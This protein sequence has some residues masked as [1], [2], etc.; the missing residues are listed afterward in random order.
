MNRVKL[1]KLRYST[2]WRGKENLQEACVRK[3]SQSK[4]TH[5]YSRLPSGKGFGG[6]VKGE[7]KG[8]TFYVH[9]SHLSFHMSVSGKNGCLQ[10][11]ERNVLEE[12]DVWG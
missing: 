9:I 3:I 2:R 7:G 6:G 10:E 4:H 12:M 5:D 11:A 8:H 1:E